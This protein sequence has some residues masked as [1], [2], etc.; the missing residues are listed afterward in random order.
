[1]REIIDLNNGWYYKA[2]YHEGMEQQDDLS[3]FTQVDLPHTNIELPYNYFD[4]KNFQ[5]QSC[6]KYLLQIQYIISL[7]KYAPSNIHYYHLNN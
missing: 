2:E 4:E 5:F 7:N 3:G 6:Y 1:M